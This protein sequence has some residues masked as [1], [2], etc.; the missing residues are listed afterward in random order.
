MLNTRSFPPLLGDTVRIVAAHKL[1]NVFFVPLV[2]LRKQ[3]SAGIYVISGFVPD[4]P[5]F[6]YTQ[7]TVICQH[8]TEFQRII[9]FQLKRQA[10]PHPFAINIFKS[11]KA[12]AF[13]TGKPN[14]HLAFYAPSVTASA[15][16][17]FLLSSP[18]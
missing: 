8:K 9:A 5:A 11:A 15:F 10:K 17:H 2:Y 7:T 4:Y 18:L 12:I 16:L 13:R 6:Y 1:I 3:K 14:F